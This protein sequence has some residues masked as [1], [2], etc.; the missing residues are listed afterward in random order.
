MSIIL[1]QLTSNHSQII[2]RIKMTDHLA[3]G[4]LPQ[5]HHHHLDLPLQAVIDKLEQR[6]LTLCDSV[7]EGSK[8]KGGEASPSIDPPVFAIRTAA[9]A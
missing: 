5:M 2:F 9:E 4:T 1:Y 6:L 8:G 3:Y 7:E